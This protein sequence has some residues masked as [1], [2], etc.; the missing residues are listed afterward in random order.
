MIDSNE[1]SQPVAEPIMSMQKTVETAPIDAGDTIVY[2]I[3]VSN[4]G[5]ATAPAYD[6]HVTDT[7]PAAVV[8]PPTDIAVVCTSGTYNDVSSGDSIDVTFTQID[9]TKNCQITVTSTVGVTEPAGE[10]FTNTASAVYSSLPGET[11][12][13]KTDPD[14]TTG[15]NNPGDPGAPTGERTGDGG[16]GALNDY[17]NTDQVD[18]T[19]AVPSIVKYAPSLANTPIGAETTFDLVVTLP[20]GTTRGLAV[21]DN[22]PIG[23]DPVGYTIV[24]TGGRL[25]DTFSG[26]LAD[27]TQ[28]A[29]PTDDTHRLW[30]LTFGDTTV[31]VN[32][33][34]G[35]EQFEIQITARVANISGNV[36]GT[37]RWNSALLTYTDPGTDSPVGVN[38][39]ASQKVTVYEP[40]LSLTKSVI[41][42][43]PT[44]ND[45][46]TYTLVLSHVHS[47]YDIAAYD[48]TL[49]DTL[50]IAAGWT[51]AGSLNT[52]LCPDAD[53]SSES[54]G[55]ITTAFGTF[56]LADVCTITYRATIGDQPA[57]HLKDVF[58]N[59]AVANWTSLSGFSS[60]ERTGIAGP[61]GMNDYR[62]TATAR[63]TVTGI[64]LAIT[65]TD[66]TATATAAAILRYV[67]SYQNN[68]NETAT[69]TTITETVPT[70][71]TFNLANSLGG[72]LLP[73]NA[74]CANGA[75]AGTVCHITVGS[76]A[77]DGEGSH[78]FAVAVVDPIAAGLT[79]ISNTATIADDHTH[80]ADATPADNT[81]T[82]NDA[83][84]Q[85]D[86]RLT[87]SGPPL[88]PGAN[89]N[90]VYTITLFN[91]GPDDATGVRVTDRVPVGLAYA[92][93]VP[94][95]GNTYV[96]A[97]G[98]WTIGGTVAHGTSK[99]LTITA[100]ATSSS[101]ATNVAEVTHSADGDPDSTPNNHVTT[102]DDYATA[103]THPTIADMAVTKT[104]SN[105]HPDVGTD[106]T[107]TITATNNG[108]DDAANAR[109]TDTLPAGL[110]WVSSM[111]SVG[112]WAGNTWT[113]G[114]LNNGASATLSLVAHVATAGLK[115]NTAT[116]AA[117]P[118]DLVSG[119]NSA[120]ATV[121][122]LL[123]LA[124]SKTVDNATPNVGTNATF[125]VSVSNT[126]TNAAHNVVI[127]DLLPAGLTWA[128]DDAAPA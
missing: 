3:L 94:G 28:D 64:D 101:D 128:S 51:Y 52:T 87:K 125:T 25:G 6:Y 55:I 66:S 19:L 5:S 97:T 84:P 110:T 37:V 104:V 39:P 42:A 56:P 115:T 83:I 75:V 59:T 41:S 71:T 91:D 62:A 114:T 47:T 76:L 4:S 48:V 38:A 93:S 67:V 53:T 2:K 127:H 14:N 24:K 30:T 16:F 122:Q 45:T 86:L 20:E 10:T 32:D 23:L 73:R 90:V 118:F 21:T 50:P 7:L 72:W 8:S 113:I 44:F 27:P 121:S 33:V 81:T 61:G 31:P 89:Q 96:S 107:F 111:P 120:S 65:K 22:L 77:A 49:V 116:V 95:A 92:S 106:V 70:G 13:P 29:L 102:E 58:D 12:T 57:A 26:T 60:F 99:T 124:V 1:L 69:G 98:V 123:D 17:V 36:A 9:P 15:S 68:G 100:T 79:Q 119:N 11:G 112:S 18:Q 34:A 82:D 54:G 40:N 63:V 74:A 78:T 117:D 103:L 105:S 88:R 80:G 85:A 126:G 109:V 46:V 43:S 35:D 108:P